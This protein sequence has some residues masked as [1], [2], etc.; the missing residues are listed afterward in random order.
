MRRLTGSLMLLAAHTA[1]AGG[2]YLKQDITGRWHYPELHPVQIS[3]EETAGDSRGDEHAHANR[4]PT[5]TV[6]APPAAQPPAPA[7]K[8]R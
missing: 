8:P 1:F 2:A 5:R 6:I 7:T 3:A 4:E